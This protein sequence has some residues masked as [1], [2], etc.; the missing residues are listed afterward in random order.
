MLIMHYK[1]KVCSCIAR[2]PVRWTVKLFT[3]PPGSPV[4]SNTN[5]TFLRRMLQLLHKDCSFT[6][7]PLS[8]CQVLVY[9]AEWSTI[10]TPYFINCPSLHGSVAYL[11]LK[12]VVLGYDRKGSV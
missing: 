7:P 10:N 2:Y 8:V 9:T 11:L 12:I 4:H 3:S 1:V 5:S 6:Y